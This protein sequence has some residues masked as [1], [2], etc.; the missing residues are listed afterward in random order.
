MKF[1]SPHEVN[2]IVN[3]G[4]INFRK[5]IR[6]LQRMDTFIKPPEIKLKIYI[7]RGKISTNIG[8]KTVKGIFDESNFSELISQ[9]EEMLQE[10]NGT[11]F[12][13]CGQNFAIWKEKDR[14]YLFNSES[15]D[16]HGNLI[17]KY[18][19]TAFVFRTKSLIPLV[20]Y[21]GNYIRFKK[22]RYELYS[23]KVNEKID[24]KDEKEQLEK[25]KVAEEVKETADEGEQPA[26]MD[27]DQNAEE[28]Q[29]DAPA[30]KIPCYDK[31]LISKQSVPDFSEH[32]KEETKSHGYLTGN[33]YIPDQEL[34]RQKATFVNCAALV[35]LRVCR[36]SLWK[37]VTMDE[38]FKLGNKI[39][40]G[41]RNKDVPITEIKPVIAFGK[42]T[43]QINSENMIFGK[44]TSRSCDVSLDSGLQHFFRRYDCG[45]IQ[46]PDSAAVWQE[47]GLYFLF[48]PLECIESKRP[49]EDQKFLDKNSC[50]SWFKNISDLRKHYVD[51]L[52]KDKRKEIFKIC[53]VDV[54]DY[55]KK[56]S[57]WNLFKAISA[58]KWILNG[59][60]SE[61][62][63][64]FQDIANNQATC[65]SVVAIGQ[66]RIVGIQNWK[67]E[68]I[69][70]V[71]NLG[72]DLYKTS[73][74][75]LTASGNLVDTKLCLSEINNY[76]A[77]P[78]NVVDFEYEECIINGT[79]LPAGD[80]FPDLDKGLNDFFELEETGIVTSCGIVVAIWK[81]QDSYY[82]FD[83]HG[84]DPQGRNIKFLGPANK[85]SL[86]PGT[87]CVLRFT[88]PT[89]MAK[90]LLAIF[91][92]DG[93]AEYNISRVE[94]FLQNEL[95]PCL[96]NYKELVEYEFAGI[97]RPLSEMH[98]DHECYKIN[99]K[100]KT[101]CN[102]LVALGFSK[103]WNARLWSPVD[104]NDML[105]M[106]FKLLCDIAKNTQKDDEQ[107]WEL[108]KTFEL[109]TFV[110]SVEPEKEVKGYFYSKKFPLSHVK[111]ETEVLEDDLQLGEE[112][113]ESGSKS[114]MSAMS[115]KSSKASTMLDFNEFATLKSLLM[116]WEDYEEIDAILFAEI[117]NIAFWKRN[118]FYFV[119]D[120]KASSDDGGL[121][122]KRLNA[123]NHIFVMMRRKSGE[124]R[125][126]KESINRK[127]YEQESNDTNGDKTEAENE[128]DEPTQVK[129]ESP[130]IRPSLLHV[131]NQ[132][133]MNANEFADVP[134]CKFLS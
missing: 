37:T 103:I 76:V 34:F 62:S 69:D 16:G 110:I 101:F 63:E 44:I 21:L 60:T 127:S 98:E 118:K 11:I 109:N 48:D 116:T 66:S 106:G 72:N 9:M 28:V 96:Y 33:R 65:T 3:Y 77:Y 51:N 19:G 70:D 104:I 20:E 29:V 14:Y 88:N 114:Q 36:S 59:T 27:N 102:L 13:Y 40:E 120:P 18:C 80:E 121:V 81:T 31:I 42:H 45:F 6:K 24:L 122:R 89:E 1:W 90:H 39:Y 73:L 32:Y 107:P 125:L 55:V 43:F 87:A 71:L 124:N 64:E 74:D 92:F 68:N 91:E 52:A 86:V 113:S 95:K 7:Q 112:I 5:Q 128:D 30:E 61:E 119:Y 26:M 12:S 50:L 117:F 67:P 56:A 99:V 57:D 78:R 131:A 47:N 97:L 129:F 105:R 58:N 15:T 83:S 115:P 54:A 10:S 38:I 79:L 35:M 41:I 8:V 134:E 49:S 93:N 85:C 100:Q 2:D 23:F 108:V 53:K 22:K 84:R 25:E 133:Q 17:D 126:M 82:I 130:V 4:D 132:V 75:N 111:E 46:G 94:P 123:F